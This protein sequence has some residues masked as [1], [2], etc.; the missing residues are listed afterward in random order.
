[1]IWQK[2]FLHLLKKKTTFCDILISY[3]CK[4]R[5]NDIWRNFNNYFLWILSGFNFLMILLITSVFEVGISKCSLLVLLF[6]IYKLQFTDFWLLQTLLAF[7]RIHANGSVQEM[8]W[9]FAFDDFRSKEWIIL[10]FYLSFSSSNFFFSSFFYLFLWSS[11]T[12]E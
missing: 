10:S 11:D 4:L 9:I 12:K 2:Q 8:F 7:L 5:V 3:V 6:L 1:M